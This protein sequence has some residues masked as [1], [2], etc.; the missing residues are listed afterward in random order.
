MKSSQQEEKSGVYLTYD[1]NKHQDG[2]GAQAQRILGIFAASKKL[3]LNYIHS[4]ISSLDINPGET[5]EEIRRLIPEA[6]SSLHIGLSDKLV[7]DLKISLKSL[8]R[9]QQNFLKILNAVARKLKIKVLCQVTYPYSVTDLYPDLYELSA[10]EI[11]WKFSPMN[12]SGEFRIDL[13][14]RRS[15][16]PKVDSFGMPY[17]RFLDS[18]W[19]LKVLGVITKFLDERKMKYLIRLHTDE[20][21]NNWKVPSKLSSATRELWSG[22]GLLDDQNFIRPSSESLGRTFSQFDNLEIASGWEPMKALNSMISSNLLITYPSSF[23]YVGGLIRSKDPV[24]S[25]K[26][27]HSSPSW[28]LTLPTTLPQEFES[29]ILSYLSMQEDVWTG[30]R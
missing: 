15:V 11:R 20:I 8:N 28:W 2:L 4:D 7:F 29:V 1:S 22:L 23:S 16:V 24:I 6:N 12:K 5:L 26:F 3:K 14:I 25:P 18:E 21:S 27:W 9:R 17:F 10:N 30:S 13:H 19:Y